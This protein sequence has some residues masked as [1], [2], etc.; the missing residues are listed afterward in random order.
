L[1]RNSFNS[2]EQFGQKHSGCPKFRSH[3]RTA[4]N[5]L[6]S[7]PVSKKSRPLALI[8]K[9]ITFRTLAHKWKSGFS[10]TTFRELKF[11]FIASQI[12]ILP[13]AVVRY[14]DVALESAVHLAMDAALGLPPGGSRC[15]GPIRVP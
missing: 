5:S 13:Q 11:F 12:F 7:E 14:D 2:A 4:A 10:L 8:R 3:P 1:Q 9:N 15:I 6:P